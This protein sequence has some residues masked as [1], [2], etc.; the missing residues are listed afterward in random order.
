MNWYPWDIE[1]A[2]CK[3]P[4]NIYVKIALNP[5]QCE[6]VFESCR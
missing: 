1:K 4:Y 5:V 6:K 3:I 2:Q